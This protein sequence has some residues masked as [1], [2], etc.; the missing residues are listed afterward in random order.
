MIHNLVYLY[1]EL[2][3]NVNIIFKEYILKNIYYL[4]CISNTLYLNFF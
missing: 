1:F 3:F 2:I 4:K